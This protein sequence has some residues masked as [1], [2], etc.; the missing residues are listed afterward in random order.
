ML[1]S[2]PTKEQLDCENSVV[3]EILTE[4]EWIALQQ[5]WPKVHSNFCLGFTVIEDGGIL[6]SAP[7]CCDCDPNGYFARSDLYVKNRARINKSS[8]RAS[9]H[10]EY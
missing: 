10:L 3:V 2:P 8:A 4:Q 9:V 5:W 7:P 1:L 6:W